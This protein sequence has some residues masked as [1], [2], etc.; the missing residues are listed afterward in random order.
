M[1]SNHLYVFYNP[2]NPEPEDPNNPPPAEI[3][4]EFAQKELAEHSGFSTEGLTAEQARV[5]EQV[6]EMLPM[7][8]EVNA[9]SEELN[10]YRHFEL[11]LLG[12]ATQDDNETKVHG[13]KNSLKTPHKLFISN[14]RYVMSHNAPLAL[15]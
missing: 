9:V 4:F 5:Q 10:K 14:G 15:H 3:D 7:I 13:S 1:G 12:A 11:I 2:K 8:S 6:L